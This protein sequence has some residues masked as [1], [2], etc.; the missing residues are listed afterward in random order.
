MD[1][2]SITV[3][4]LIGKE[5]YQVTKNYTHKFV[6]YAR[7]SGSGWD[8]IFEDEVPA[9]LSKLNVHEQIKLTEIING[10]M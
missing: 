5:V 9:L 3:Q 7:N 8:P 6:S 4:F 10:G 2:S 1:I